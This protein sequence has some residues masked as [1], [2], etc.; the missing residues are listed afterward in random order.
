MTSPEFSG[1]GD[2]MKR[3]APLAALALLP[4][5]ACAADN[6]AGNGA[7]VPCPHVAVLE[8]AQQVTEFL[9]GRTDVAAEIT[10][11]R[12]TGV[13]GACILHQGRHELAVSL[14]AGFAASDGPADHNAPVTLPYFVAI[15]DGDKILSKA[16]YKITLK[17]DGNASRAEATSKPVKLV[18][19]GNSSSERLDVLVGFEMTPDQLAY[20][21]AHPMAA[22]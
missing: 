8:Q 1:K 6:T 21:T 5:S 4:I 22:P 9:P 17:F 15:T 2:G 16:E 13:A 14:K 18:M 20:S 12:I 3:F 7:A 11:A 10:T 19:P